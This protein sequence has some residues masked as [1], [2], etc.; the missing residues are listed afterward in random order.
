MD[1]ITRN[2]PNA[3]TLARVVLLPFIVWLYAGAQPGAAWGSAWLVLFAALTDVA[4]GIVARRLHAQSEFGVWVDPIVDRLFFFVLLAMLLYFGALPWWVVVPLLVRD[5][6]ILLLA[7]PARR[8]SGRPEISRWGKL[9]NFILM[10]GILWLMIDVRLVGWVWV[11]LG[12]AL[13]VAS[14]LLYLY[15]AMAYLR[16]TRTA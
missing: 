13:Y 9:A 4:D 1:R 11:L 12:G 2:I 16:G 5:G 8:Y 10:G 14:G 6:L 3:M 7:G 15:R